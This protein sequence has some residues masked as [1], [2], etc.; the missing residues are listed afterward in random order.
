MLIAIC[1]VAIQRILQ[2]ICLLFRSTEFKELE[3]VVLR[4]E[5]AVLRRHVGRPTFRSGDR[6]FFATASRLLPRVRWSAFLVTPT[7]LLKW[8]NRL[9]AKRWTYPRRTGR[10]PIHGDVRDVIVRVTRENPRWGYLRIVAELKGMGIAVS[11]ATVR[12]I[13]RQAHLGPA[14]RRPG[15][16]LREFL[17][18]A[19]RTSSGS[20][21]PKRSTGRYVTLA[22]SRSRKW[23]GLR[24]AGCSI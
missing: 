21:R 10:P 9:V 4:H 15:P 2:L 7:T 11:A 5:L 13:L 3:I 20:T 19:L 6:V 14:D 17:T 22:P 18:R 23:H 16:P 1:C 8:H 24:T 12:K